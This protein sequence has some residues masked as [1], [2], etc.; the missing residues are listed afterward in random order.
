MIF[1]L[2]LIFIIKVFDNILMTGK[3]ILVQKNR[4]VYAAITVVITQIIFYKLIDA[5]V[6]A[7]NDLTMLIVSVAS[8]VGTFIALRINSRFSK[9][10]TYVNVILSD[11]KEAI[12]EFGDYLISHNITSVV[13]DAYTRDW[14]KTIALTVYAETKEHSSLVSDYV[15]NSNEK[16]KRVV[17]NK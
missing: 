3:T 4:G 5:V 1:N 16:F 11:N 12:K 10:Q 13:T 7:E 15:K 8:G 9:E 14:D 6:S 17:Y 2:L